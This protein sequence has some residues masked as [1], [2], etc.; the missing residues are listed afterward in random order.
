MHPVPLTFVGALRFFFGAVVSDSVVDCLLRLI[1]EFGILI[2]YQLT[3]DSPVNGNK[4]SKC[5][6]EKSEA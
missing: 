1:F 6:E 3:A 4:R 2:I 5:S